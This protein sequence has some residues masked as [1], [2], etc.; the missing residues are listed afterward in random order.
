MGLIPIGW[1]DGLEIFSQ[2]KRL[3]SGRIRSSPCQCL[4]HWARK[5]E[6]Q[7]L[8]VGCGIGSRGFSKG[9]NVPERALQWL[10]PQNFGC[11]L[12]VME[13][14]PSNWWNKSRSLVSQPKECHRSKLLSARMAK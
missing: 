12:L 5:K 6:R 7:S 1:V 8:A 2:T 4:R 3:K 14:T 9:R 10:T 13:L 11:R